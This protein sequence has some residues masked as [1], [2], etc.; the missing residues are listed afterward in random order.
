M[1]IED[2]DIVY[3]RK[4]DRRSNYFMTAVPGRVTFPTTLINRFKNVPLETSKSEEISTKPESPLMQG[5]AE[6]Y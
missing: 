4:S 2:P 5:S 6:G 1:P 3:G